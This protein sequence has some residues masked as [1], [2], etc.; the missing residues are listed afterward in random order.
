MRNS[1]SRNQLCMMT[2]CEQ[3]NPKLPEKNPGRPTSLSLAEGSVII[4]TLAY[5]AEHGV[6]LT[7]VHLIEAIST[8]I[9]QLPCERQQQLPFPNGRP[10][11]KFVRAFERQ[12]QKQFV[13][14]RPVRQEGKQFLQ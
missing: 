2:K 6:P 7:R 1:E 11:V 9:Q 8:F 12:H 10:G 14:S 4:N 13:F 5:F 3:K